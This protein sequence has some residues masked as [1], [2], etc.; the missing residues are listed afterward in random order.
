[1]VEN[2]VSNGESNGVA[3]HEEELGY[4]SAGPSKI[5]AAVMEKAQREF[6]Q[7]KNTQVSAMELSHRS[8]DYLAINKAAEENARKLLDVPANYKIIFMAGGGQGQFAAVPLNLLSDTGSAD[9]V[10][11]GTWSDKGIK[12]AQKY[13]TVNNV[14]P[15]KSFTSVPAE[16]SW[17]RDP[18]ADYIYLCDNETVHGLEYSFFPSQEGEFANVPVVAD[19]SSNIMSK[20]VDVS[21]YGLIYAAAQKNIGP[22]GMTMVIIREDLLGKTK[23]ICPT[24]L[25]YAVNVKNDSI[26]N[27]P[28][29]YSLYMTNLVFEWILENGGLD[30][31][32][33]EATKKSSLLYEVVDN[34]QGFYTS[35]IPKDS[36]SRCN[37]VFRLKGGDEALEAEFIA[38]AKK[39]RLLALKGHRSVGGIRA[40]IYNA[41]TFTAVQRLASFMQEFQK[42][43]SQ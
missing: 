1:M 5:P 12:E 25:D 36:R 21:K 26:V 22:A 11:T 30:A 23:K 39:V 42:S 15:Q 3:G 20:R 24:I 19:M 43:H 38:Q 34:S 40:S 31:M 13:G 14:F 41:V 32:E 2:G 10:V 9:Y 7:Y 18:K 28:N 33:K 27:T 29:T 16:E 17:N 35:N 4:F 8:P 6:L 37:V